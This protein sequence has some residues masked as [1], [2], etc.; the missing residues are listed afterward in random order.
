MFGGTGLRG[1]QLKWPGTQCDHAQY[2]EEKIAV[3]RSDS[4]R[5][6]KYAPSSFACVYSEGLVGLLFDS[7]AHLSKGR[8][9]GVA[10]KA[11]LALPVYGSWLAIVSRSVISY[12]L[13]VIQ[14]NLK[15]GFLLG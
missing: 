8:K 4:G 10:R 12:Q 7:D 11:S 15:P 13:V 1:G 14:F 5:E 9:R 2:G 6:A 3:G